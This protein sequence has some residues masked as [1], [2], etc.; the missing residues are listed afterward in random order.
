MKDTNIVDVAR[1]IDKA[2]RNH[3]TLHTDD[4]NN[5]Y[6]RT[7]RAGAKAGMKFT[8]GHCNPKFIR[9][10]CDHNRD[11]FKEVPNNYMIPC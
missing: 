5:G 6:E 2:M 4:I 7:I 10:M 8:K 9:Q 11:A 1:S 3:I